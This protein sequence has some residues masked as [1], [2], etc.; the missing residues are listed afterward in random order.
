MRGLKYTGERE[1]LNAG[2]IHRFLR[3]D[4]YVYKCKACDYKEWKRR[5]SGRCYG[6]CSQKKTR[7]S[8][9][10]VPP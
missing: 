8:E 4:I 7:E 10:T 9:N 3:D 2:K 5:G 6:D 1:N